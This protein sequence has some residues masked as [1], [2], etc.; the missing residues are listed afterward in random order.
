M[1]F[2]W[3]AEK[4]FDVPL[5][6]PLSLEVVIIEEIVWVRPSPSCPHGNKSVFQSDVPGPAQLAFFP[7]CRVGHAP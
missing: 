6:T 3:K 5:A 7:P 4:T 1:N 2:K